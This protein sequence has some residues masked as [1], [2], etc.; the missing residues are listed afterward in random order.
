VSAWIPGNARGEGPD[1]EHP[2]LRQRP[3]SPAEQR[4]RWEVRAAQWR[5]RELA[6]NVFGSVSAMGLMGIR[7]QGPLR[8]LLRLDVPFADLEIHRER[9]ARFLAAVREDP[10]LADVPL[11]FLIGPAEG[12]A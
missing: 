11:V 7:R 1:P 5:A 10:L 12:T 3:L 4:A 9:E 8:G 2:Q 6:E